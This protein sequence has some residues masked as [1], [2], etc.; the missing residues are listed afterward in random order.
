MRDEMFL[1]R[2]YIRFLE[3]IN[4]VKYK[5]SDGIKIPKLDGDEGVRDY[6]FEPDQAEAMLSYL[7]KY[8]SAS[9]EHVV[10]LLFIKTGRRLGGLYSLDVED[11]VTDTDEPY[12]SFQHDEIT[13]LKN[14]TASNTEVNIYP[15]TVKVLLDYISN[16]RC[17]VTENGRQPLLTSSDG[18]LTKSTMR[19]YMYKFSRPCVLN[20]SCPHDRD[21]D[22]CTAATDIDQASKCPSS[23]PPH[24]AR[25]GHI[26]ELRR[27]HIDI[28][29]IS[30]RCDVSP[31]IIK[32]HYDERNKSERRQDR[33]GLLDD[34]RD[35]SEG[36]FL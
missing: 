32:K 16:V 28:D 1:I 35:N 23:V 18:R 24:A 21:P 34:A 11:V 30:D 26:T 29:K 36:G 15:E 10:C 33:R 7:K 6:D 9:I 27:Q 5:F 22:D 19:K 14:D 2:N 12:I 4:A 17:D 25:H 20:S 8:E 3:Q 31:D 13:Q